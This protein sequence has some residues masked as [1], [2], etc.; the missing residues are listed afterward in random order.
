MS[1]ASKKV[2]QTVSDV[3]VRT[4][5]DYNIISSLKTRKLPTPIAKPI[6]IVDEN[7]HN[8]CFCVEA[9]KLH[10]VLVFIKNQEQNLRNQR[11]IVMLIEFRAHHHQQ[12]TSNRSKR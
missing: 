10:V 11:L 4:T 1:L 7:V 9:C 8:H 2:Q 6:S 12:P 5:A 3:V